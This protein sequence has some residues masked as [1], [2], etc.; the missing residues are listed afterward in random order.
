MTDCCLRF[1]RVTPQSCIV[2]T[3]QA[4][5]AP[6]RPARHPSNSHICSD[7]HS[8]AQTRCILFGLVMGLRRTRTRPEF[9]LLARSKSCETKSRKQSSPSSFSLLGFPPT[10]ENYLLQQTTRTV[11]TP[12]APG[13]GST[14]RRRQRRRATTNLAASG[15][16]AYPGAVKRIAIG[17]QLSPP[18]PPNRG[19]DDGV[20]AGQQQLRALRGIQ[21]PLLLRRVRQRKV[22]LA[23]S[24]LLPEIRVK[25]SSFRRNFSCSCPC[26]IWVGFF[27]GWS[28]T[29]PGCA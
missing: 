22:G 12:W 3:A 20:P 11:N 28:S 24:H 8:R 5:R 1:W 2:T 16:L 13:P 18:L 23:S 21:P 25:V 6:R 7:S 19:E 15:D 17:P 10:Q 4:S 29:T 27:A 26:W 14:A 9:C